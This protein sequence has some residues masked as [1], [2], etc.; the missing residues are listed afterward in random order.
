MTEQLLRGSLNEAR[1]KEQ[2]G[3]LIWAI[4]GS[5]LKNIKPTF[6]GFI[7]SGVPSTIL[8]LLHKSINS[9]F[10]DSFNKSLFISYK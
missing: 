9:I 3:L 2:V 5:S 4:C 8:M 1:E 10:S 6:K 7:Y